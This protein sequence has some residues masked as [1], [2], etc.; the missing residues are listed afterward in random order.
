MSSPHLLILADVLVDKGVVV[1][2][3]QVPRKAL[4][5]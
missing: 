3:H 1:F 2:V 5:G 4:K